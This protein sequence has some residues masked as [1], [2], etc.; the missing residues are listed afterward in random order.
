VL[1]RALA[2]YFAELDAV[3]LA[4]LVLSGVAQG[5]AAGAGLPAPAATAVISGPMPRQARSGD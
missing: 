3:T 5:G 1:R 2:A 4:D